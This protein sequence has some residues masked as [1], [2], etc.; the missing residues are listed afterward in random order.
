M[1]T[2]VIYYSFGG[3]TRK[4]AEKKAAELSAE[5]VEIKEAKPRNIFTAFLPGC[6]QAMAQKAVALKEPLPDFS[7]FGRIIVMMPIWAGFPA[8]AFNSVVEKLPAGKEL[9]LYL[10]SGSGN[11]LKCREKV[12]AFIRKQGLT[13]T[14]YQDIKA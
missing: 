6:T 13:L 1:K 5:L 9:E 8:P 3:M 12:E 10:V 11:S 7:D 4:F 14:K 2:A